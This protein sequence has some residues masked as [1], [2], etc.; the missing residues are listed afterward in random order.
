MPPAHVFVCMWFIS[1]FIT[2]FS[3]I[4]SGVV[5]SSSWPLRGNPVLGLKTT[6]P[7]P[8][9]RPWSM[10]RTWPRDCSV[11]MRWLLWWDTAGGWVPDLKWPSPTP[12]CVCFWMETCWLP[13]GLSVY[14]CSQCR[15]VSFSGSC[16]WQ[17]LWPKTD[18]FMI[19]IKCQESVD[20][21]VPFVPSH[22]HRTIVEMS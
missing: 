22:T 14:Y 4:R 15:W 12:H 17:Q 20:P 1:V 13:W 8:D 3:Q 10:W 6:A 2:L 5:P 19:R 21:L 11:R 9:Q 7:C 18:S 16:V